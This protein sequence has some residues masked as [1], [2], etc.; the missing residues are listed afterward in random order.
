MF[1]IAATCFGV[2]ALAGLAASV[3]SGQVQWGALLLLMGSVLMIVGVLMER[4]R[5]RRQRESFEGSIHRP[6]EQ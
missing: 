3:G 5:E 6:P 1:L 4:R 2:L